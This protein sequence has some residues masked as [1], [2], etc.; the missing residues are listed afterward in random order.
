MVFITVRL[1]GITDDVHSYFENL[2]GLILDNK[3]DFLVYSRIAYRKKAD[4]ATPF[5]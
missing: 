3:D 5:S 2:N 4:S 1:D